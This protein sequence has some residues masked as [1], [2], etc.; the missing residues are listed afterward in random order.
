ME[1]N[2]VSKKIDE[3]IKVGTKA[4]KTDGRTRVVTK[5]NG[6]KIQMRVGVKTTAKKYTTKEM[7]QFAHNM[8]NSGEY[9]TSTDLKAKYP[10]EY[11][12]GSCV[13]S[14]TGGIL[15]LVDVARCIPNPSG[16]GFAYISINKK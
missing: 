15:E 5:I 11:D 7:I 1:W 6:E 14:M 3:E 12:Q 13:F 4:P 8:I 2:E 9:F 10:R 16:R